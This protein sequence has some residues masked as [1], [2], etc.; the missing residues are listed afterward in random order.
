VRV[1]EFP[2]TAGS[3]FPALHCSTDRKVRPVSSELPSEGLTAPKWMF[4]LPA[5]PNCQAGNQWGL[6]CLISNFQI[7][8]W[9]QLGSSRW[10]HAYSTDS[11]SVQTVHDAHGPPPFTV[12]CISYGLQ[13][14]T[15]AYKGHGHHPK[16]QGPSGRPYQSLRACRAQRVPGR[17]C[18][19]QSQA[20]PLK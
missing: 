17:P 14:C 3:A 18:F 1:I 9:V 5:L 10:W 19:I 2:A 16:T 4:V 8:A 15:T 7:P 13:Y 6:L 11:C 20:A 12:P